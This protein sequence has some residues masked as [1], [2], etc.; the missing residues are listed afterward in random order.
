MC[1]WSYDILDC[2]EA[3][4]EKGLEEFG[5]DHLFGFFKVNDGVGVVPKLFEG[6]WGI[7]NMGSQGCLFL[8]KY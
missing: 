7:D 3:L 4:G 2:G 6:V 8:G 5:V 1:M